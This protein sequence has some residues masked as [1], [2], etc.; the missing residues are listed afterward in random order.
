LECVVVLGREHARG[1]FL[2]EMGISIFNNTSSVIIFIH[3]ICFWLETDLR[4]RRI[5]ML[6]AD[7]VRILR[8]CNAGVVRL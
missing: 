5:P 3:T 1:H 8:N 6:F 4:S 7:W 2:R